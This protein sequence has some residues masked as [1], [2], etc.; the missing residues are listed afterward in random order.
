MDVLKKIAES[1]G[2]ISWARHEA[3]KDVVNASATSDLQSAHDR[4]SCELKN[5]N[6][7]I[8]VNEQ[9]VM[10]SRDWPAPPGLALV[11]FPDQGT[12]LQV[13][14]EIGASSG[15]DAFKAGAISYADALE[16]ASANK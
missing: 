14:E 12:A 13:L 15:R 4:L 11:S 2:H 8:A 7:W 1:G 3:L 10:L 16:S 6:I 5:K 9:G